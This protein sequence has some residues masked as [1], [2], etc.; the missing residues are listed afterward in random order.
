MAF[1]SIIQY[2]D[3]STS[4]HV[5]VQLLWEQVSSRCVF[6]WKTH[7]VI[8]VIRGGGW[9]KFPVRPIQNTLGAQL[10]SRAEKKEKKEKKYCRFN[11]CCV[12][13]YQLKLFKSISSSIVTHRRSLHTHTH[14]SWFFRLR[15]S[16]S[17]CE[18]FSYCPPVS[19]F[20]V[21]GRRWSHVFLFYSRKAGNE[22]RESLWC[23]KTCSFVP[24]CRRLS[25]TFLFHSIDR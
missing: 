25:I 2:D 8:R 9:E 23:G 17:V 6:H 22:E 4:I 20:F 7:F 3:R 15:G 11:L 16:T 21:L 24:H 10:D 19:S 14:T 1:P 18:D 13:A 12:V 5:A